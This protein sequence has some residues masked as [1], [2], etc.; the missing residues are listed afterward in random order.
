MVMISLTV[1]AKEVAKASPV[2]NCL[3]KAMY[4]T[5][6][7]AARSDLHKK[8]KQ[9]ND[10]A[11]ALTIYQEI[12]QIDIRIAELAYELRKAAYQVPEKDEDCNEMEFVR[13][14]MKDTEK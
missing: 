13:A 3:Q 7:Q 5:D 11:T 6:L 10:S 9:C 12:M 4:I 14:I 2:V 1:G 8:A